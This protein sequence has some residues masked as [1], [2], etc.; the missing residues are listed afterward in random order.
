MKLLLQSIVVNPLY[1]F[2]M[3]VIGIMLTPIAEIHLFLKIGF[4]RH[5]LMLQEVY[6]GCKIPT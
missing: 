2:E 4:L 3:L 1:E 5:L 6:N